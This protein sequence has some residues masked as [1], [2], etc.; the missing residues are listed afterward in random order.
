MAL[1]NQ[2]SN[3]DD[4]LLDV[5]PLLFV[6]NGSTVGPDGA[7][8]VLD[9]WSIKFQQKIAAQYLVIKVMDSISADG[10]SDSTIHPGQFT[11]YGESMPSID[12]I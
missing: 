8:K 11:L 6:K 3:I 7:R 1:T 4:Q 2:S 9:H 12:L 5:M 10:E